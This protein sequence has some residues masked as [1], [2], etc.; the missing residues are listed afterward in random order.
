LSYGGVATIVERRRAGVNS[1]GLG[2]STIGS[3]CH[4]P[5]QADDRPEVEL[6]G[7]RAGLRQTLD[8]LGLVG[9]LDEVDAD[10]EGQDAQSDHRQEV[11]YERGG[12]PNPGLDLVV[13]GLFGPRL[14]RLL[15][16]PR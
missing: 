10:S 16:L 13:F 14:G 4:P 2:G 3:E 8:L 6:P 1:G 9:E 5:D 15:Q 11:E 7:R 12:Q